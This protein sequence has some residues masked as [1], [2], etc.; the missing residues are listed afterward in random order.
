LPRTAPERM[1]CATTL[2][3]PLTGKCPLLFFVA[4]IA[5]YFS[6]GFRSPKE[7]VWERFKRL[8][9]PL[10]FYMVMLNPLLSYFWPPSSPHSVSDF[11][12]HFWPNYFS[13]GTFLSRPSPVEGTTMPGW[14]NLW[15][16][17]YL[18]TMSLI[19]LPL[20]HYMRWHPNSISKNRL[21]SLI[22]KRNG[23]FLMAIPLILIH[24]ILSPIW[25]IF[26]LSLYKDWAYFLCNL[27]LFIYGYLFC[28]EKRLWSV[29]S[30]HWRKSL[31]M[32]IATY[33]ILIPSVGLGLSFHP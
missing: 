21:I 32:G 18:F 6:L 16:V 1:R 7:Y 26:Q 23:I 19:A 14:A 2:I 15:F 28:V 5:A 24:A 13:T 3:S 22:M 11:F 9:V 30:N 33:I 29:V 8:I 4:G 17:V 12:S 10:L 31:L 20:F 27:M 25:P